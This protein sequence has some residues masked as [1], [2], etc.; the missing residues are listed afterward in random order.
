MYIFRLSEAF[1]TV[2]HKRFI[3]KLKSYKINKDVIVRIEHYLSNQTQYVELNYVKSQLQ[4]VISGIPQGSVLVPL[5]LLIYINDLPDDIYSAL[6]M[7]ADDTK[8]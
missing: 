3:S 7:Y 5:F 4:D 6:Y 2:P 8:V 1:D